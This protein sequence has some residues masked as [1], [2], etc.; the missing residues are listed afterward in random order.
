[1][2][3][4]QGTPQC[5]G[6]FVRNCLIDWK[7]VLPGSA[8]GQASMAGE[9]VLLQ[10]QSHSTAV[11][12]CVCV[13]VCRNHRAGAGQGGR[14]SS[15]PA[16]ASSNARS[17]LT[18]RAHPCARA[19]H[20]AVCHAG[21]LKQVSLGWTGRWYP[22]ALTILCCRPAAY[23]GCVALVAAALLHCWRGRAGALGA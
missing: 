22:A 4:G 6:H 16:H 19:C 21:C 18:R 8:R 13:C 2:G 17:T 3:C 23:R 9:P 1:M 12:G 10:E 14:E 11:N 5:H 15:R 7:A 20:L